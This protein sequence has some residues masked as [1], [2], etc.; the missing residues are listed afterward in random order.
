MTH[1]L[2]GD[3]FCF[4][5]FCL[6][7]RNSRR[8][9]HV[10]RFS[11][12]ALTRLVMPRISHTA[13]ERQASFVA[14]GPTRVV[15]AFLRFRLDDGTTDSGKKRT[16]L[17]ARAA[18]NTFNGC[19]TQP[20]RLICRAAH[21]AVR[22]TEPSHITSRHVCTFLPSS[23]KTQ[24]QELNLGLHPVFL[25]IHVR[26]GSS[27]AFVGTPWTCVMRPAALLVTFLL[28][29]PGKRVAVAFTRFV[30]MHISTR[31]GSRS[32]FHSMP[33]ALPVATLCRLPR[34][35]GC[36]AHIWDPCLFSFEVLLNN[37]AGVFDGDGISLRVLVSISAEGC[38]LPIKFV[39]IRY[40]REGL[41]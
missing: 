2:F 17:Q 8:S 20:C 5:P 24:S 31:N 23:I 36:H 29:G 39:K 28:A 27:R 18:S 22:H 41:I 6:R 32:K 16:A 21:R 1:V 4:L 7:L 35:A 25:P 30:C 9:F 10:A 11:G 33:T 38:P 37:S 15:I 19:Q 14:A 34:S 40:G 12:R 26:P 3:S 13:R